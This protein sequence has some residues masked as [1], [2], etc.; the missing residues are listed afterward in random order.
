M[1]IWLL[2]FQYCF[3]KFYIAHTYANRISHTVTVTAEAF[4]K[5]F[6]SL[7]QCMKQYGD[8]RREMSQLPKYEYNIVFIHLLCIIILK[9]VYSQ[10]GAICS[11]KIFFYF[12]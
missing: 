7:L 2:L 3:Y 1:V 12:Q 6:F 4:E 8:L 10:F 5:Q 11:Y 9:C